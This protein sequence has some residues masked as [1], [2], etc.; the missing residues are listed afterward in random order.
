[1]NEIPGEVHTQA[2][3]IFH[4]S[5]TIFG[6][7]FALNSILCH[8]SIIYLMFFSY[9]CYYSQILLILALGAIYF[10]GMV[11]T[12]NGM[13]G[14]YSVDGKAIRFTKYHNLMLALFFLVLPAF[15]IAIGYYIVQIIPFLI[16][17]KYYS[18]IVL[19]NFVWL[20]KIISNIWYKSRSI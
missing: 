12:G 15:L 4:N 13:F 17:T 10:Y 1:M 11:G 5:T 3:Q 6:A 8:Q 7:I 16:S 18:I 9:R 20:P 2:V 19:H 14:N